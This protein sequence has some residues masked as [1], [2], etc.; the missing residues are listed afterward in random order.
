MDSVLKADIFRNGWIGNLGKS[1]SRWKS[2]SGIVYSLCVVLMTIIFTGCADELGMNIDRPDSQEGITLMI[3]ILSESDFGKS[4]ASAQTSSVIEKE[5]TVNDLY[6]YIFKKKSDATTDTDDQYV[7]EENYGGIDIKSQLKDSYNSNDIST[8]KQY[9][10]SLQEGTYKIFLLGNVSAY[11]ETNL[12]SISTISE[13]K[14]ID[15]TFKGP[16][17]LE[18]ENN[19]GLPM[20]CLSAVVLK[21]D[22]PS[23]NIQEDQTVNLTKNSRGNIYCDM[24]FLCSKVRYTI[25]FDQ[26]N[27][28]FSSSDIDFTTVDL[29]NISETTPVVKPTTTADNSL[30]KGGLSIPKFKYNDKEVEP[31][32]TLTTNEQVPADLTTTVTTWGDET[33]KA[34]Q[35]T[36]YFPENIQSDASKKTTLKF[37]VTGAEGEKLDEYKL[38]LVPD[39]SLER[40][41]FYDIA[42]QVKKTTDKNLEVTTNVT[43]WTTRNLSYQLHGSFWLTVEDTKFEMTAGNELTLWYNTDLDPDKITFDIP[44]IKD[45]TG[46]DFDFYTI[47]KV[48]ENDNY[49]KTANGYQLKVTINTRVGYKI[50]KAL[51]EEGAYTYDD[52]S[53]KISDINYFHIVAGNIHKK[54]LLEPLNLEGFLTVTPK[55]I[56]V[57]VREYFTSGKGSNSLPITINTNINN[58]LTVTVSDNKTEIFNISDTNPFGLS[59]NEEEKGTSITSG[60]SES[61]RTITITNGS[62]EISLDFEK[63]FEGI[64]YWKSSHTYTLTFS[65]T[66]EDNSLT[67]SETVTITVKPYTTD[68]I[69]HF[70][71]NT[72]S[73]GCPHI[74]VYQCLELPADLEGTNKTWA[75]KTVGY[76]N[77]GKD[78]VAYLSALEYAFTNNI[79]FN[80]WKDYGGP[81][82]NDPNQAN[83]IFENGFVLLGGAQESLKYRPSNGDT[84]KYNFDANLNSVHYQ[85]SAHWYCEICK[86][87]SNNLNNDGN[88][89][90]PGIAMEYEDNGWWKYTLTGVATPGKAMI[91]FSDLHGGG[92]EGYRYPGDAEVGVPLFDYP[93]NEGWFLYDGSSSKPGMSFTNKEPVETEVIQELNMRTYRIY[94]NRDLGDYL[95]LGVNNINPNSSKDNYS[96]LFEWE[97]TVYKTDPEN[98]WMY[99]EFQ[100]PENYPEKLKYKFQYSSGDMFSSLGE[101]KDNNNDGIY[102]VYVKNTNSVF[103]GG[104]PGTIKSYRIYWPIYKGRNIYLK[105]SGTTTGWSSDYLTPIKEGEY[106]YMDFDTEENGNIIYKYTYPDGNEKNIGNLSSIFTYDTSIGKHC[107]TVGV[108]SFNSVLSS[109]PTVSGSA[110]RLAFQEDDLL[111]L[112]WYHKYN[113]WLWLEKLRINAYEKGGWIAAGSNDGYRDSY[114]GGAQDNTYYTK[115]FRVTSTFNDWVTLHFGAATDRGDQMEACDVAKTF[116][117]MKQTIG[118]G[119]SYTLWYKN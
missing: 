60:T 104:E 29:S 73:W 96:T 36:I 30:T 47:E 94:W 57:D 7:L 15:L 48:K 113:D 39:G 25:L 2:P 117:D 83:S 101:F 69:I 99:V 8:Y 31:Y 21:S 54:I 17:D 6:L 64:A 59:A 32:L 38:A 100:L 112:R 5:G 93:D 118:D 78:Y 75:G 72:K 37:K 19:G 91:M 40:G 84:E 10:V 85:N 68:Y 49:V 50:M 88:R 65:V 87:G 13:L 34:W 98:N 95:Y 53:W 86:E 77:T 27:S 4:R 116:S 33:E 56:L 80:G 115:T 76:K 107:V 61:S 14:A 52:K 89:T 114:E 41:N 46:E 90:Y 58:T 11:T 3:P 102:C 45:D 70:K 110:N 16:I 1:S 81:D 62:G 18:E 26:T 74:Y 67:K 22:T 97:K 12:K 82:A 108:S 105:L 28:S 71:D 119:N 63:L 66:S 24:T 79:A 103:N 111:I 51:N 44:Q 43:P 9:P 109:K 35:H 42:A 20:A 106:Y 55:N 23:S 92:G